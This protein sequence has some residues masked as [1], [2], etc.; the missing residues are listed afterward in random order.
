MGQVNLLQQDVQV[1]WLRGGREY[2]CLGSVILKRY[3]RLDDMRS[4]SEKYKL[5]SV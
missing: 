4:V 2:C 1:E 3:P 5:T